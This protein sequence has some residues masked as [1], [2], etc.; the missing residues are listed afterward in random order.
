MADGKEKRFPKRDEV[1]LGK[2]S[3]VLNYGVFLDLLQYPGVQGFVHISQIASSW[4]KNIRSVVKENETRAGYVLH[5]DVEK[6]QVDLSFNRVSE[7]LEKQLIEGY[8]NAQKNKRLME[9]LAKEQKSSIEI[10]QKEVVQPLMEQYGTLQ[11]AFLEIAAKGESAA[12][13]VSKPWVKPLTDWIQRNVKIPK[14]SLR[15]ELTLSSLAPNGVELIRNALIKA[16]ESAKGAPMELYY[17]GSG[18]YALRVTGDD[19]KT[20][21]KLLKQ[22]S[23]KAIEL[24]KAGGGTGSFEKT[25]N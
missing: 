15:G 8:Q 11:D 10:V 21:E 18:K 5:F 17:E 7:N 19:Y 6:G 14:K 2:V 24:L 13:G 16:R 12:T 3:K 20:L 1:V 25:A 9:L 22:V 4:V 23:D